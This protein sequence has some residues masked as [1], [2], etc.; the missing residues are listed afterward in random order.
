[1]YKNIDISVL[2]GD[3]EIYT[4][5]AIE[6]EN[7]L[8]SLMDTAKVIL[9]REFKLN[10][11][12]DFRG[13]YLLDLIQKDMNVKISY[14]YNG[15]L[16]EEFSGYIKSIGADIPVV[17]ECE[18]EMSRL[19]K[20]KKLNLSFE[21]ISLED[22]LKEI[23]PGYQLECTDI[24]LGKLNIEN[25]T[26]YEVLEDLRK[27]GIKCWFEGKTLKAGITLNL[28]SE[29]QHVFSFGRNI[30][31][32]SDLEYVSKDKKEVL[33]KAISLQ[34]GTSEKVIYEFGENINGERT[35]HAPL[36][37]DKKELKEWAEDYYKNIVFDGYEGNLD[38]WCVP[39][40]KAGDALSL[41]D[42]NYPTGERDGIFLIESVV[43][44]INAN[45]GIKRTN[46]ISV[47]L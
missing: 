46:K 35:L 32:S 7:T 37:L 38:G 18:D 27:F 20:G 33:I 22:L 42:P 45:D 30:R 36:N 43:T 41:T 19:K 14:G 34:K 28:V 4:V 2:I 1:M 6:V 16:Q 8:N 25:S 26:A 3:L 5:E 9:P 31:Q 39:R 23:A 11:Q 10:N 13:K 12:T 44:S 29:K 17:I 21:K 15:D 24:S 47:K 40:T